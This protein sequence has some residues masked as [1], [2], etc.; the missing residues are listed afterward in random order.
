MP[1]G[2]KALAK[3]D[4]SAPLA[5]SSMR[6]WLRGPLILGLLCPRRYPRLLLVLNEDALQL[7]DGLSFPYKDVHIVAEHGYL[8]SDLWLQRRGHGSH[9]IGRC[10]PSDALRLEGAVGARRDGHEVFSLCDSFASFFEEDAYRSHSECEAFLDSLPP[11]SETEG[12]AIDNPWIPKDIAEAF[13]R[14]HRHREQFRESVVDHNDEFVRR[15]KFQYRTLF[16]SIE[17]NPL[18]ERQ[19]EA[20]IRNEDSNLVVA[21]AGTGKTSCV[22]ARIG[23][24]LERGLAQ[25]GEILVLAYAKKAQQELEERIAERLGTDEV[26][27]RTFHSLGLE[28][29]GEATG[30]RPSLSR[31]AEDDHAMSSFIDEALELGIQDRVQRSAI[32]KL[33]AFFS[34]EVLDQWDFETHS[35]YLAKLA[36]VDLRTLNGER[37]K[38]QEELKIANWLALH[39]VA[40]EYERTYE[41]DTST[42]HKRAYKPD[43]YLSDYDIY[44]EHF[45][46]N[47]N[48]I[49]APWIDPAEYR[50]SMEWKRALHAQH[51][52]TLIETYSYQHRQNTWEADLEQALSER[53]VELIEVSA[54]EMLRRLRESGRQSSLAKFLKGYIDLLKSTSVSMEEVA[55]RARE[56]NKLDGDRARAFVPV[57]RWV[58]G[59][60]QSQLDD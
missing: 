34:S 23:Y 5:E 60:Y 39:G 24:L 17:S 42:H 22:V 2:E 6:I 52:T 18:T 58:Y 16:S 38:S 30:S 49:P 26:A 44:L 51:E 43:F 25:P 45:G 29:C 37:V 59:Q 9:Y 55:T 3:K 8:T 31:M 13:A 21:G 53:E 1:L 35:D 47:E 48:G 50:A 14:L 27:I 28:I 57:L 32:L 19:Q 36:L 41:H 46:V 7:S 54:D 12:Q 20:A 56:V 15:Q 40:Y 4:Q 33:L 11:Q 10:R